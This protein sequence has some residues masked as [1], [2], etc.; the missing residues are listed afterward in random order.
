[1]SFSS[2]ITGARPQPLKAEGSEAVKVRY[3]GQGRLVADPYMWFPDEVREVSQEMA[4]RLLTMTRRGGGCCNMPVVT[5]N[6]FEL[7]KE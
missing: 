6:L 4:D 3:L 5:Y 2:P 1:M 7:V